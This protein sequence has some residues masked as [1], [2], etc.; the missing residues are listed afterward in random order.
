MCAL[1]GAFGTEEHWSTNEAFGSNQTRRA[2]RLER[3]RA[4][5][6]VLGAFAMRLDDWQ[7]ARFILSGP[8]GQRDIVDALPQVWEAAARMLGRGIDPLDP[9]LIALIAERA[10]R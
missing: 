5:N 9:G 7:G 4:A 1:C 3:V 6:M 2:E 8:T 10:G